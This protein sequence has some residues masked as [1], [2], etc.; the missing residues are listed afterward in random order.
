ME[1]KH[2]NDRVYSK[3]NSLDKNKVFHNII[4]DIRNMKPLSNEIINN[5]I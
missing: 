1:S 3:D 4:H 5:I 2:T